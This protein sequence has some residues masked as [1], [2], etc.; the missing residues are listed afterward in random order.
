MTA[1]SRINSHTDLNR[2]DKTRGNFI[3]ERGDLTVKERIFDQQ[4]HSHHNNGLHCSCYLV[5]NFMH[6]CA[7][8]IDIALLLLF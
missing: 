2:I 5:K 3:V 7:R 1:S 4:K 8:R 6:L